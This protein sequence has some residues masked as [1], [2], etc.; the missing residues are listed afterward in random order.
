[1]VAIAGLTEGVVSS[2]TI[3]NCN[4][5][6]DTLSPATKCFIYPGSHGGLD[7]IQAIRHSCNEYFCEVGF[8]LGLLSS[9]YYGSSSEEAVA[10]YSD[11]K[12]LERLAE[13]AT[14]FGLNE[15]SGVEI[16]E[17][18]PQISDTDATR[19]SIGQGTNNYATVQIA[20]YIT[21]VANK[22]TLYSL[23]LLDHTEDVNGKVVE[24]YKKEVTREI[25]EV[26][27]YTWSTV[28]AGMRAV[29]S[30]G[31]IYNSLG[32]FEMSGKTGTAQQSTSHADHGLFVGYAPSSNPEIAFSIRIKNGYTSQYVA[33]VGRDITRYYFGLADR[34]E[35][36]G[37]NAGSAEQASG[38]ID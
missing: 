15:K 30:N 8:R 20:R 2:S 19:S 31:S 32:D 1:M 13:Y 28:Q 16:P 7:V 5:I 34:E 27:D 18:V 29:I 11:E 37:G 9:A 33:E 35:L 17:S 3:V 22:G 38:Y 12:G 10:N 6:Y 26:S 25:T 36:I 21:A 24:K 4:G 23:T 14:L